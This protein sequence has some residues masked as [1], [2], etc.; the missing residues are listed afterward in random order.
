M[1]LPKTMSLH[2]TTSWAGAFGHA[3]APEVRRAQFGH[4]FAAYRIGSPA[5]YFRGGVTMALGGA[6][7]GGFSAHMA[8]AIGHVG[9]AGIEGGH[10]GGGRR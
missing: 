10:P 8:A 1:G 9:A 3:L 5:A 2:S 4:S 6:M 7:P